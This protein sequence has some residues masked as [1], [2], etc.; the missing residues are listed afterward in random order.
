M[1]KLITVIF[2]AMIMALA[3]FSIVAKKRATADDELKTLEYGGR[4]RSYL[5]HLP[6]NFA[7][8]KKMPLVIDLHGGG[9][10][11]RSAMEQTGF[12]DLADKFGFIVVYPN[13][14]GREGFLSGTPRN[15]QLLT[16]NAGSCCGYAR[17]S[18]V[19]DVGF[20]RELIK[21]LESKYQIDK[22][23]IYVTGMSNGG[24]MAYRLACE[25]SD[26][27]A[28]IGVVSGVMTTSVCEPKN[29]VSVIHIHG[30]MDNNVPMEGGVG[31]N[32]LDRVPKPP[33]MDS[34]KFWVKQ[35]KCDEKPEVTVSGS[36]EKSVYQC[37]NKD[38]EVAFYLIK[39]GGHAWPGGRR[40]STLLDKPAQELSASPI[41]WEFFEKHP[42]S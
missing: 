13:G 40:M 41:I 37:K 10:T 2:S 42:K 38:L 14:T 16:W 25:L 31:S 21:T 22:K 7:Q 5:L 34:I 26:K 11:G 32:A 3:V 35:N 20:I 28:A 30:A 8:E 19:D 17:N 29:P 6:K 39:N 27:I 15:R 4:Q 36:V 23:R 33:V 9:G 12:N 1:K 18:D 24:M